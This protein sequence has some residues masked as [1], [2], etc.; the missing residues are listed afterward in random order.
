[1][2]FHENGVVKDLGHV[3]LAEQTDTCKFLG[4]QLVE[5]FAG[6]GLRPAPERLAETEIVEPVERHGLMHIAQEI[7]QECPHPCVAGFRI[8]CEPDQRAHETVPF[9]CSRI[10]SGGGGG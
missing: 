8:G 2:R 1:M 5:R 4:R 6:M 10:T 7:V 3:G 9:P